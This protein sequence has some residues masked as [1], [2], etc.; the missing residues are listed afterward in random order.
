VAV[1]PHGCSTTSLVLWDRAVAQSATDRMHP[2][3]KPKS[4]FLWHHCHDVIGYWLAT[5]WYVQMVTTVPSFV[6]SSLPSLVAAKGTH[7]VGVPST[8]PNE[9]PCIFPLP[10][11]S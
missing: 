11:R 3:V 2:A 10:P 4:E 7:I 9:A 5:P 1:D 6:A 8:D